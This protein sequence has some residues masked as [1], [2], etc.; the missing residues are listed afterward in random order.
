[1]S[2][3]ASWLTPAILVAITAILAVHAVRH[4]DDSSLTG[5]RICVVCTDADSE[6]SGDECAD[7][8][9]AADLGGAAGFGFATVRFSDT[10]RTPRL[11]AGVLAAPYHPPS[12]NDLV[13]L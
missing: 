6:S 7:W 5:A 9:P 4:W 12:L 13:G 1:M 11:S 3:R 2:R 8:T 10:F